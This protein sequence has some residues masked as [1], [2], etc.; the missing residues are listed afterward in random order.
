MEGVGVMT[1]DF[2]RGRR[3]LVTGHTGFKGGWLTLW[4][5][6]LGAE[7]T[8]LALAP[9]TPDTFFSA[10]ELERMVRSL[11]GD[12]RDAATVRRALAESE[13]EVVFHLAAQSLVRRSYCDP[14]ATFATN[15]MGTLN[16]L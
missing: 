5:N 6:Q 15:V 7:V 14:E 8:G 2:W 1:R 13:A 3:V 12:I 4:L 10:C 11:I 9:E 16:V